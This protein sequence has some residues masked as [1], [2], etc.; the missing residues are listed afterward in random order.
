[1]KLLLF[2][3]AAMALAQAQDFDFLITNGRIVDGTGNPSWIGDVGIRDGKVAAIGRL[4]GHT[5]RRTIDATGLI[6]APGF[7][8]IHNHS[9]YAL[10]TDG[11]AQSMIRQG[12][13]TMVLGE[14]GSAA[15]VGGKQTDAVKYGWKDFD[16]YFAK[17]LKG[18]IST[19]IATYVGSSQIWTYVHGENAGPP[20][21][22]ELAEMQDLVRQA[23]RQGALG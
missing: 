21:A 5:A 22:A 14:G 17:L 20:S 7:I 3:V 9:D 8:D 11:D 2:L 15:P 6:V 19:N 1:M 10:L 4:T 16:G 13:T 23:M 12:V 18:G